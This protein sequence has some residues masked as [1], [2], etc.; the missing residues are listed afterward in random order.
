MTNLNE[1]ER[2]CATCGKVFSLEYIDRFGYKSIL[3]TS[4]CSKSCA[5]KSPFKTNKGC[6]KEDI[7]KDSI[8]KKA[9]DFI[10]EKNEYCTLAEI[11][12]GVGHSSKTFFKHGLKASDLN[13]YH[14]FIKT[15]SKFQTKVGDFLKEDFSTIE[16]EKKFAGLV[17]VKGHPLRVDF[18]I[19]EI[20][21]VIEADGSQHSDPKHPWKEWNNGTVAD[22]D[23]IK[24]Q[25]FQENGITLVRVPYKRNL[26]KDDILSRLN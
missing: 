18:Y 25:Y 1:H 19:P 22:Y 17:G 26:K 14:G 8:L 5:S 21:T 24:N 23:E 7:G 10:Q 16:T 15:K 6:I 2:S 12:E 20:N 11:C 13:E 9:L 4:H 3:N